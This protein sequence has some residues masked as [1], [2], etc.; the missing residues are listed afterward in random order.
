M[1]DQ[2]E[3]ICG[4]LNIQ[5]QWLWVTVVVILAVWNLSVSSNLEIIACINYDMFIYKW[6]CVLGL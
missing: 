4:L 3:I 6:K 5:Y 1:E 2:Q